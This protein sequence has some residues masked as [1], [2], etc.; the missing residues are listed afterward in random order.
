MSC[1][2]IKKEALAQV[3]SCE[4]CEI[5]RNTFFTALFWTIASV[6]FKKVLTLHS[7]EVSSSPNSPQLFVILFW[8]ETNR[9]SLSQMKFS[10]TTLWKRDSNTGVFLR[11]FSTEQLWWLLLSKLRRSVVQCVEKWCSGHLAQVCLSYLIPGEN[12]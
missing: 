5:S 7:V 1:N 2:F 4:F 9:N 6:R 10:L 3:F 12:C 11:N 8:G